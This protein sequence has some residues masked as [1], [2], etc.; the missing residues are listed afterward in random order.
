MDFKPT[1]IAEFQCHAIETL[2]REFPNLKT[3]GFNSRIEGRIATPAIFLELTE[4]SY[5]ELVASTDY[6]L[7]CQFSL[8]LVGSSLVDDPVI[9][10]EDLAIKISRFIRGNRWGIYAEPAEILT[11]TADEFSPHDEAYRVWEI[12]FTQTIA[13]SEN[14]ALLEA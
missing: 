6:T 7:N 10:L 1:T 3:G 13:I 14:Q 2:L 8:K 12:R 11:S 4:F 5:P 9:Q